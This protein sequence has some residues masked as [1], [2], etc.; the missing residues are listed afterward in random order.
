MSSNI[1]TTSQPQ[2]HHRARQTHIWTPDEHGHY[3]EP[4]WCSTRL[5]ETED[6]GQ[7]GATILDP[8]AGWGRIP[9]AAKLA[10]F[11]PVASDIVDRRGDAHAVLDGIPFRTSDFLKE[12]PLR[13]PWSIVCNPPYDHMKEFC[14]QACA[15]AIFKVAMLVP[16]RRLPAAGGW[17]RRLPLQGITIL[18][19]RPSIPPGSY[20]AAGN[21]PSGGGQD[22]CWLIFQKPKPTYPK[23]KWLRRSAV[24]P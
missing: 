6:F 20:I 1:P 11:T 2:D 5:F 9:H 22:F 7:P 19:P 12:P 13:A 10:D 16:I 15:I 18:T 17:L 21:T 24:Q 23:L 14:E 8:A 3:V 4:T